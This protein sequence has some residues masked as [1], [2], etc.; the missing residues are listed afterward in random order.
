MPGPY[1]HITAVNL[2]KSRIHEISMSEKSAKSVL[3]WLGALEL[4]SVSPD[5]PYLSLKRENTR[6]ADIMHYTRTAS[7]IRHGVKVVRDMQGIRQEKAIAW[8]FGLTAHLATDTT[9]HPVIE[10]K[11][12]PYK[13]NKT[14]HRLCEMH[15]DVY[16]FPRLDLGDV[17]RTEHLKYGIAGCTEEESGQLDEA[18]SQA[19]FSTLCATHPRKAEQAPPRPRE[20]HRA[21][22]R[23]L[24][25]ISTAN[26]HFA[27]GRH[28]AARHSLNYPMDVTAEYVV[29]LPTP[30]GPMSYDAI[31]DRAVTNVLATWSILDSALTG[32]D[33]RLARLSNWNL[34]TGLIPETRQLAFWRLP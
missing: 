27:F 11:V 32:D 21:F 20:W 22:L 4:G 14:Q 1:A 24:G 15:Q 10:R 3:Y 31:F 18:I 7:L 13:Y 25:G 8:L 30:E 17:G 2:A 33:T 5:Y 23:L 29:D 12:G 26:H 16:I 9:I 19:W 28:V 34:D 6:W